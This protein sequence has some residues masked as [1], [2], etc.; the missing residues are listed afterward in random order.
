[1]KTLGL[2][3]AVG[4][5][6]L[7]VP[8]LAADSSGEFVVKGAGLESCAAYTKAQSEQGPLYLIARSWLNGYLTQ[9]NQTSPTTYDIAPWQSVDFLSAMM[10]DYCARNP[11]HDIVTAASVISLSLKPWRAK[12]K[13][14]RVQ[15]GEGERKLT[16]YRGTVRHLQEALREKGYYKG[17]VDGAF[18]PMTSAALKKFQ[19]D[20]QLEATA[21]PDEMTLFRLLIT[22]E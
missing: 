5:Y 17:G 7:S 11:E 13:E 1:M 15:V 18:G 6:L 12:D 8:A 10:S 3:F 16:L 20:Q 4:L 19:S 14:A 21:V 9:V 22:A 2:K